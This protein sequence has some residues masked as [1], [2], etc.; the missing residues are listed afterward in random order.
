MRSS[1]HGGRPKV[2]ASTATIR[3]A[4]EQV[5]GLFGRRVHV[6]P[7]AGLDARDSYFSRVDT[8]RAGRLYVGVMSQSHTAVDDD[9]PRRRSVVAGPVELS[10]DGGTSWTPTG[11]SSPTT[12]ASGSWDEPSRRPDDDIPKAS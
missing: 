6:F 4:D 11:R 10:L 1:F 2:L 3:R 9:D 5:A 8:S 7:P 12:T